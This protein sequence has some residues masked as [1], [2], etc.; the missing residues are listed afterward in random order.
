[1]AGQTDGHSG[2]SQLPEASHE[3]A[4]GHL[5]NACPVPQRKDSKG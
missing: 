1:M 5:K 4:T 2:G 3:V